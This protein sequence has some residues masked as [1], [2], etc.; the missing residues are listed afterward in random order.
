MSERAFEPGG[1]YHVGVSGNLGQPLFEDT[2]CHELYLRMYGRVSQKYHW[3]T[4]DWCLMWNHVHFLVRLQDS[5]LSHGMRELNGMFARRLNGMRG[6]TG[7]GHAIKHR[8]FSSH[9]DSDAYL[10]EVCRYIPLNPCE[11]ALC[12][13]PDEWVWGGYRANVGLEYARAF[14]DVQALLE[15]FGDTPAKARREYRRL[16]DEGLVTLGHGSTSNERV[17]SFRTATRVTRRSP[18]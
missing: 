15:L 16:V 4:L 11:A 3:Q 10:Q 12:A 6:L 9:I 1:L 18:S 8:F 14:H 2:R 17:G 13:T 5:G 7:K